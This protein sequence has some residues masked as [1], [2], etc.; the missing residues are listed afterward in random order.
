MNR[1]G[2]LKFCDFPTASHP[3]HVPQLCVAHPG[4]WLPPWGA[5]SIM[6]AEVHDDHRGH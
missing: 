3:S 2:F 1:V 5:L 4:P 6:E